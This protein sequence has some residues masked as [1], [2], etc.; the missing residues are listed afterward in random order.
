MIKIGLIF[1]IFFFLFLIISIYL[2]F[3]ISEYI[4][5]GKLGIE[6]NGY[7]EGNSGIENFKTLD[8]ANLDY[9]MSKHD[10][11]KLKDCKNNI[12]LLSKDK[13][14]VPQGH[15][16]SNDAIKSNIN[17][18]SSSVDGSDESPKNMFIFAYNRSSPYC[19]PSTYS[20]STGCICAT[21][22]QKDFI[23]IKRGN[24]KTTFH[25]YDF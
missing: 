19:C 21:K 25:D 1:L 15:S 22:K 17:L 13:L 11:I 18:G 23:N 6:K 5:I 4:D 14:Y 2:R 9:K 3:T 20:T 16:L 10:S 8:P 12:E 7:I 24:N